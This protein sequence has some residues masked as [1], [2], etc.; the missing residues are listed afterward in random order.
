MN[1][2]LQ[3]LGLLGNSSTGFSA[4]NKFFIFYVIAT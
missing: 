2:M 4:E 3:M 1:S